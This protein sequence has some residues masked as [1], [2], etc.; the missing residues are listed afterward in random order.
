M[1]I[2]LWLDRENT[3]TL[4]RTWYIVHGIC[5]YN[6]VFLTLC[7]VANKN[8]SVSECGSLL[9]LFKFCQLLVLQIQPFIFLQVCLAEKSLS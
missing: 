8:Y 4:L 3:W 2:H 6:V 9:S 1:E 7:S 5:S